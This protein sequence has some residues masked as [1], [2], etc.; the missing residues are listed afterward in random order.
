MDA[1]NLSKYI[2]KSGKE[3]GIND[4]SNKKL[5]KLL[6]YVQAWTL[7]LYNKKAFNDEIEAWVHGPAIPDVYRQYKN[8]VFEAIPL[9]AIGDVKEID[10]DVAAVVKDVLSVYGKYDADYLE[11]LSHTE[12]PWREARGEKMPFENSSD[13]ISTDTM[14]SYYGE[15]LKRAQK[16]A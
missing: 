16:G 3:S 1:I 4:I 7:V 6:Y 12:M 11:V 14:K 5:Q 15:K 9:E 2:I 8:F 10:E 13:E